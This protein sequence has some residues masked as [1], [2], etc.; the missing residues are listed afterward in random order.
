MADYKAQ[1]DTLTAQVRLLQEQKQDKADRGELRGTRRIMEVTAY[2]EGSCGKAPDDLEYGITSSG[3]YV[4]DGY[5]AAGPE[6]KI[7][8]QIYIPYFNK[9]FTV[10]DRG[11]DIV[12]GHLDVYMRTEK[13]CNEFGRVYGMEV[14]VVAMGVNVTETLKNAGV[15]LEWPPKQW[16]CQVA[17]A[18]V[19]RECRVCGCTWY[20][21]CRNGCYWVENDL[22]SNCT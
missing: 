17:L 4:Q 8:Q 18:G 13:L 15:I 1:L 3:K 20:H 6:F 14:V 7:G 22:C 21:G 10:M 16:A 9:T 11:K 2:W 5:I 19:Q 12:N